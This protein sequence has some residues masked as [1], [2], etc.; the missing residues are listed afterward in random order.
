MNFTMLRVKKLRLSDYDDN[1]LTYHMPIKKDE[2]ILMVPTGIPMDRVVVRKTELDEN[3]DYKQHNR[4]TLGI[5]KCINILKKRWMK[6]V[7]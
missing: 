3:T 4:A 7:V 2:S 5:K 6:N 1:R